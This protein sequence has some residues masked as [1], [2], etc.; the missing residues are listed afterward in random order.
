MDFLL[1]DLQNGDA[2]QDVDS[3]A[4]SMDGRNSDDEDD[5]DDD[6]DINMGWITDSDSNS[7]LF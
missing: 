5:D 2:N 4:G 3:L 7:D 1:I 6:G